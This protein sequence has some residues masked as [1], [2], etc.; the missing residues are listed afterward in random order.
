MIGGF[1]E[2]GIQFAPT[3]KL[4]KDKDEYNM[5]RI[6]GWTDRVIYQSKEKILELKAYDS[7]NALKMSDHWAVFA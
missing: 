5:T 6:P 2:G 7:N 4:V 1:E 3:Y